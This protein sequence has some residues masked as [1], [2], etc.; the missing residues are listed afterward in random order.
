MFKFIRRLFTRGGR[1]SQPNNIDNEVPIEY[2]TVQE[3]L[4]YPTDYVDIDDFT[5]VNL[6]RHEQTNECSIC[7]SN[8]KGNNEVYLLFCNHL[9]HKECLHNWYRTKKNC[10]V[11]RDDLKYPIDNFDFKNIMN[12][13]KRV[14]S[15]EK[16]NKKREGDRVMERDPV[17]ERGAGEWEREKARGE[18]ERVRGVRERTRG[19]RERARGVGERERAR[20]VGER[21]RAMEI[22]DVMG[23]DQLRGGGQVRRVGERIRER[24]REREASRGRDW[25]REGRRIQI[26]NRRSVLV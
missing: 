1:R 19:E 25:I 23:R 14:S 8:F 26:N 5:T 20:G 13:T 11:C 9:F 6:E 22:V 12:L 18:R 24:A 21:E 2:N 10:P 3:I 4:G 16:R 15:I 17:V 7:L